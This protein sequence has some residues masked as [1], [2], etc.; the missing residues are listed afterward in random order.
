MALT[1]DWKDKVGTVKV[2]SRTGKGEMR[3]QEFSLY[4]GNAFLICIHEFTEDDVDK[5]DMQWFFV[6][7]PHMNRMLGLVKGTSNCLNT[8]N[9]KITG[10]NLDANNCRNIWD[11]VKAFVK[12]FGDI[13]INF[14]TK[15]E[16]D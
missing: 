12:A 5:Y 14:Y 6:D 10:L 15:K 4:N 16:G 2:L 13:T 11:I 8:E 3:E 7:K 9:Y 1:W